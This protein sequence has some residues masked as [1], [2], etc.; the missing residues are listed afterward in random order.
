MGNQ[1]FHVGHIQAVGCCPLCGGL[2][3]RTREVE[4]QTG[5]GVDFG[6]DGSPRSRQMREPTVK[7]RWACENG[8]TIEA[9][10]IYRQEMLKEI[11]SVEQ[12]QTLTSEPLTGERLRNLSPKAEQAKQA[13]D[14]L[15]ERVGSDGRKGK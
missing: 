13:L 2:I 4:I 11:T 8:C 10:G 15:G 1:R 3:D 9:E 7:I 14:E 6:F 12:L 5:I